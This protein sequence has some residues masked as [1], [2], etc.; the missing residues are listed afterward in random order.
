MTQPRPRHMTGDEYKAAV[1]AIG[2]SVNSARK[3]FE[4][5]ES[6]SR[7]YRAGRTPVPKAIAMLL[8]LMVKQGLMARDVDPPSPMGTLT[9]RPARGH[10]AGSAQ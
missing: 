2:L 8:R 5:S 1:E 4:M 6:T 10:S 9:A 3:F 7:R